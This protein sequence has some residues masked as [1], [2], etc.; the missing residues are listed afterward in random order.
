MS[1]NLRR[2]SNAELFLIG[3]L[4]LAYTHVVVYYINCFISVVSL[5]M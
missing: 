1:V 5:I 3:T 2:S 4:S